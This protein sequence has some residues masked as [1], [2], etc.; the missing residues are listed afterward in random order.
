[1]FKSRRVCRESLAGRG[2][3]LIIP[4]SRCTNLWS[5]FVPIRK[6]VVIHEE[7]KYTCTDKVSQKLVEV[8]ATASVAWC[9]SMVAIHLCFFN[10]HR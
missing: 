2:N 5:R 4:F 9:F 10:V 7:L 6:E 8:E 3:P 1:M